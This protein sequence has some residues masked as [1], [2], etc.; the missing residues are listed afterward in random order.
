MVSLTE[1]NEHRLSFISIWKI[2]NKCTIFYSTVSKAGVDTL[3]NSVQIISTS[4]KGNHNKFI[5]FHKSMTK[6]FKR[7]YF[8][9]NIHYNTKNGSS[10]VENSPNLQLQYFTVIKFD[11]KSMIY[12]LFEENVITSIDTTSGFQTK[13]NISEFSVEI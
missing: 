10:T 9:E 5:L 8:D 11:Y 7:I 3:N 1:V 13:K 4:Q 12:I 6:G 2:W